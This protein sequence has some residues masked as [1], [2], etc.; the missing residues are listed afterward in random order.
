MS[1][2]KIVFLYLGQGVKEAFSKMLRKAL[3]E[4]AGSTAGS[5]KA[6]IVS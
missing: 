2:N 6:C 1:Q 5:K 4:E 3:K